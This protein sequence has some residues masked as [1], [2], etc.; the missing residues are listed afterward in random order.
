M[1][2]TDWRPRGCASAGRLQRLAALVSVFARPGR[3]RRAHAE[4]ASPGVAPGAAWAAP[5]LVRE[6]LNGKAARA[7]KRVLAVRDARRATPARAGPRGLSLGAP[8]PGPVLSGPP[9]CRPGSWLRGGFVLAGGGGAEGGSWGE[10]EVGPAAFLGFDGDTP[11]PRR[12]RAGLGAACV[13]VEVLS[14]HLFA[15]LGDFTLVVWPPQGDLPD[16]AP[17]GQAPGA[18]RPRAAGACPWRS[19]SGPVPER[20]AVRGQ[21]ECPADPPRAG[22]EGPSSK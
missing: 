16:V 5:G 11:F 22:R 17:P 2:G 7:G 13:L 6:L 18:R 1:R 8:G 15:F 12:E 9:P 14:G 10:P 4:V 19:G 21:Q 20:G 3:P